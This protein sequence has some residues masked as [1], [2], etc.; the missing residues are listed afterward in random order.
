MIAK[1]T[2]GCGR[3]R[4][5]AGRMRTGCLGLAVVAALL[6]PAAESHAAPQFLLQWGAYGAGDGQFWSPWG[7]AVDAGGNVYVADDNNYRVE[8]FDSNGAFLAKWGSLGSGDG[9]FMLPQGIAVDDVAQVY[10]TDRGNG[11]LEKFDGSGNLVHQWGTAGGADGQFRVPRGLAIDTAGH[12]YVVDQLNNRIEKFDR[13]GT[14]LGQWGTRGA[15]D[16]QFSDDFFGIA[17]DRDG[18]VY[19]TDSTNDCVQKFDGNGTFLARWGTF[20]SGDGQFDKPTGIAADAHGHVYVADRIN[21]RVQEF[22]VQGHFL[23]QWGSPGTGEG[24]FDQPTGLAIDAT[25]SIYVVEF[26]NH[27]VQKFQLESGCDFQCLGVAS[28]RLNFPRKT[29]DEFEPHDGKFRI[30]LAFTPCS[31]PSGLDPSQTEVRVGIG[32]YSQVFPAGSLQHEGHA[33]DDER[34]WRFE[35]HKG[36]ATITRLEIEREEDGAWECQISGRGLERQ[37]LLG[38]GTELH[39]SLGLGD[40]NG[41][42][43]ATLEQRKKVLEFESESSPCEESGPQPPGGI[44][45]AD[46]PAPVELLPAAP[47]PFNPSTTIVMRARTAGAASLQIFD[48]RGRLVRTLLRG[49]VPAGE[50]RFVW[51]GLDESGQRVASGLY[52]LRLAA[53][54]VTSNRKLL[55]AK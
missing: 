6:G 10:V 46:R 17:V 53:P 52:V 12:V 30:E 23:S 16:G 32:S 27:R 55:L 9:Q 35:N 37:L 44:V 29:P 42:A 38:D 13:D 47:N 45:I 14:F 51:N 11:R 48:A 36:T 1:E 20:G 15:G 28:A 8:K 33:D 25:G 31:D 41:E 24:Q 54:G 34:E 3:P 39:V 4:T 49:E 21:N 18:N 7:V 26:G 5:G 40:M 19:V 43:Q 50:H 2:F 22:D